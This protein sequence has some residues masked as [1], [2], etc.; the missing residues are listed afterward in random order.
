MLINLD[1]GNPIIALFA[2]PILFQFFCTWHQSQKTFKFK[3]TNYQFQCQI[4][5]SWLSICSNFWVII[6]NYA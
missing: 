1:F 6:V 2:Y 3:L 5:T 4:H